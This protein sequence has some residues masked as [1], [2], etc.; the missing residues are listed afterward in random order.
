MKRLVMTAVLFFSLALS[1]NAQWWKAFS[2]TGP[3]D[4]K[5]R[6]DICDAAVDPMFVLIF[7][8]PPDNDKLC[9]TDVAKVNYFTKVARWGGW[10]EPVNFW[11]QASLDSFGEFGFGDPVVYT[12]NYGTYVRVSAAFPFAEFS[13]FP[14]GYSARVANFY[15]S[16]IIRAAQT[17]AIA[18]GACVGTP[19]VGL[20]GRI[21][22]LNKN[23]CA[24]VEP[25]P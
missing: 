19:H 18:G 11:R 2:E 25:T 20:P 6:T 14:V 12:M 10:V 24:K 5:T 8:P 9:T 17:R 13:P 16:A 3:K 22:K 4:A 21:G 1:A 15:P 7:G 23:N